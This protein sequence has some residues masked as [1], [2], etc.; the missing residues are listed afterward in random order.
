MSTG[1]QILI[2]GY[3]SHCYGANREDHGRFD[4]C[5]R[6]YQIQRKKRSARVR[7]P[8][9]IA[10][11]HLF[12]QQPATM[13]LFQRLKLIA[14]M[15]TLFCAQCFNTFKAHSSPSSIRP[16]QWDASNFISYWFISSDSVARQVECRLIM[17]RVPNGPCHLLVTRSRFDLQYRFL[18]QPGTRSWSGVTSK[19]PHLNINSFLYTTRTASNS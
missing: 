11:R 7:D 16:R 9:F 5:A 17:A 3:W 2:S 13:K 19:T 15:S 1:C 4:A 14:V 18:Y 12:R 6:E 8:K 10:S